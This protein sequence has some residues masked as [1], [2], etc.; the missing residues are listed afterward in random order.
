MSRITSYFHIL[1]G[2]V[3]MLYGCAM[4]MSQIKVNNTLPN[5]TK[6]NFIPQ[7]GVKELIKT[8]KSKYL[9]KGR[10]YMAP[11]GLTVKSELKNGAIGIDEWVCLLS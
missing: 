11:I 8:D 2:F 10:G 6:S 4:S 7:T 1:G 9:V 3:S 5:L